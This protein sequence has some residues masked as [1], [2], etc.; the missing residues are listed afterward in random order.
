MQLFCFTSHTNWIGTDPVGGSFDATI[1]FAPYAHSGNE[2]G[3]PGSADGSNFLSGTLTPTQLLVKII[4]SHTSRLPFG[5]HDY[6][7][8]GIAHAL[9]GQDVTVIAISATGSGKSAY[10]Y[11]L[12]TVLVAL[13]KDPSLVPSKRRFSVASLVHSGLNS[14]DN[15]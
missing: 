11:M 13:G 14:H 1:F 15:A 2:V 10:I 6:Q 5:P 9:D 7:L 8:D 3:L 4:L 12:A